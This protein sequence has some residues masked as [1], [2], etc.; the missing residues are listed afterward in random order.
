MPGDKIV[1]IDGKDATDIRDLAKITGMIKGPEN[2]RVHITVY[3]PAQSKLIEFDITR[4]KVTGV[5]V[6]SEVVSGNI[7]YMRIDKFDYE[8]AGAFYAHLNDLLTNGIKGLMIDVRD[9]PGGS[10]DQVVKIADM[11]LPKGIIVYTEDKHSRR[12]TAYSNIKHIDIPLVVLVNGHSASASE[13]LAGAVKDH[14]RGVLVGTKTFGKGLVQEVRRLE[15]GSGLNVTVARY[16]TPSGVCIHG[17]GIQ[18]DVE[19][20]VSD[21]YKG[22]PVYKIPRTDD[23][24]FHRGIDILTR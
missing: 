2:T 18:P 8:V 13:I 12:E 21:D 10:Y 17:E 23:V 15:D 19:V 3:R 20:Q 6:H 11:L 9:N 16:F 7:G 5:Y 22:F 24:Q 14:K 1:K 4:G